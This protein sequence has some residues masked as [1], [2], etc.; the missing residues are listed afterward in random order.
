MGDLILRVNGAVVHLVVPEQ[1]NMGKMK[2]DKFA[3]DK[4]IEIPVE[5]KV[6]RE[7][8]D[9]KRNASRKRKRKRSGR[10]KQQRSAPSCLHETRQRLRWRNRLKTWRTGP[11]NRS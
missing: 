2:W 11:R 9:E 8:K 7:T 10:R 4:G 6:V 5:V 1:L 3:A